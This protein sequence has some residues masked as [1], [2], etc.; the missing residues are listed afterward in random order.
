MCNIEVEVFLQVG[1]KRIVYLPITEVSEH[2]VY[3]D[4]TLAGQVSKGMSLVIKANVEPPTYEMEI[5][6]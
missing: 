5:T 1:N 3:V 6:R 2:D 4:L